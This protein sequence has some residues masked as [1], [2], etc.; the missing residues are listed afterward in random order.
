MSYA[1][2]EV[3]AAYNLQRW[4]THGAQYRANRTP[5]PPP[6]SRAQALAEDVAQAREL[7]R[8]E[9]RRVGRRRA[10]SRFATW[11]R[12]ERAWLAVGSTYAIEGFDGRDR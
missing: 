3:Q 7:E 4:R 8:L 2:P 9:A 5:A 1:D 11:L 10:A 6:I 12:G